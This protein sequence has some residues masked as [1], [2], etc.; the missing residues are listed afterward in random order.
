MNLK[1]TKT[2]ANLA[3]AFA[4]E[5][6]ARNKYIFYAAKARSEGY[7]QIADLFELTAKN[8]QEHAE[9]WFN[10]LSGGNTG[11]TSHNLSDAAKGENFEWT[12]MYADFA[13]QAK[14]EG[15]DELAYLFEAV[16]KI[17]QQHE[18]RFNTLLKNV[19]EQK[20]FKKDQEQEWM[21][22]ECGYIHSATEA[23]KVCPVCKN[24][25]KN[26]ALRATNY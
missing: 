7:E 13:T 25:Q 15:F 11:D 21:C 3:A 22:S 20:V 12:K 2:E 17:E 14:E 4:G 24:P 8:E 26:F 9:M 23:P 1:G 10:Y 5:S 19:Q 18:E 16:G 6:Q